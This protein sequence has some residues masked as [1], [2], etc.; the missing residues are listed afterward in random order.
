MTPA[1][2]R[3]DAGEVLAGEIELRLVLEYEFLA[4]ERPAQISF[5]ASAGPDF[6][7]HRRLEEAK[8]I[9]AF[10]LRPVE[11]EVGVLEQPGRIAAVIGEQ[12][13]ADA[14]SSTHGPLVELEGRGEHIK[15]FA[16]EGRG[17]GRRL[18][19]DLDDSK[20]VAAKPGES[21]ALADHALQPVGQGAQ[22]LVSCRMAERVVHILEVIE[23]DDHHGDLRRIAAGEGQGLR[24]AVVEQ[25]AIGQPG[26]RIVQ[27]QAAQLFFRFL[28][29]GY[30]PDH[31]E[32]AGNPA[33]ALADRGREY[34]PM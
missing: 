33:V 28:A 23:I 15:K 11:R 25:G 14:G 31:R 12:R 17:I 21:I 29:L 22:E 27:S 20:F 24:Q 18:Q 6:G 13:D 1:Y 30:V 16:C 7:V 2:Q 26:Q 8:P 5:Q 10:I 34:L 4:L 32:G 9:A 19:A 3:L